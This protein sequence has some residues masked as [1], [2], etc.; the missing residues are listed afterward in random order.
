MPQIIDGKVISTAIKE[1]LKIEVEKLK[2]EH[3]HI[4]L[5]VIQVG[6]D[7]ASSVYVNNKKKHNFESCS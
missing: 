1:E 4:C 5:A 2:E 7:P 6:S 3:I